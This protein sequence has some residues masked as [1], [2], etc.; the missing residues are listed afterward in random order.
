LLHTVDVGDD[1]I[2]LLVFVR[3]VH[4]VME[5]DVFCFEFSLEDPQ[6]L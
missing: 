3:N 4:G 1:D 2:N 5:L 6:G